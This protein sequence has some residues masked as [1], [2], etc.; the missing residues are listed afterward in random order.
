MT[1]TG[2]L[3]D[4]RRIRLTVRLEGFRVIYSYK[5]FGDWFL[6]FFFPDFQDF[7]FFFHLQNVSKIKLLEMVLCFCWGFLVGFLEGIFILKYTKT[8]EVGLKRM[9]LEK[10]QNQVLLNW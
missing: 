3:V 7:L 9:I 4:Y 8:W 10:Q 1:L 5:Y 2:F 6:R